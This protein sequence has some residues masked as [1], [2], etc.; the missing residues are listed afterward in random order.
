MLFASPWRL[1]DSPAPVHGG[2]DELG[3][4]Q[5]DFSSNANAAGPLASVAQA[6]RAA[7]RENYPDPGYH[8]LRRHLGEWHGVDPDRIVVA[9]SGSEFIQRF[10]RCAALWRGI[11]CAWV[12]RPGYGD[13]ARAAQSA[14]LVVQSYDSLSE[15]WPEPPRGALAWFTQPSSPAG[16]TR[17]GQLA[18][19]VRAVVAENGIAVLDLA[20]QPLR[21]IEAEAHPEFAS[22]RELAWQ[23]FSPNKACG[24]TGVR[25]AYAIAP[26]G[27]EAVAQALGRVAASWVLGAEG[28]AMLQAFAQVQ[29]QSEL[30]EQLGLLSQWRGLL[31]SELRALGWQEESG[32]SVTPFFL[33]RPPRGLDL[34][35]LRA[36]GIKLRET[37]SLGLPGWVRISAQRPAA[38]A[39]LITAL[40]EAEA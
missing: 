28:V 1:P 11:A 18:P 10:T 36:A 12:P 9:A 30:Q 38:V 40:K 22:A 7:P 24:L 19:V 23:L 2:P 5:F 35:R 6:V 34:V 14:G 27:Q 4:A 3:L 17:A 21:L 8:R 39:A 37:A 32:L 25:G 33:A 16:E 15:L 29:A 13:Y 20:Y 26:A 31:V